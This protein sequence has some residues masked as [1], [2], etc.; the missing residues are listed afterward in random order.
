MVPGLKA[1]TNVVPIPFSS[2]PLMGPCHNRQGKNSGFSAHLSQGNLGALEQFLGSSWHS[3]PEVHSL[4]ISRMKLCPALAAFCSDLHLGAPQLKGVSPAPAATH[5][6]SLA[7]II[8]ERTGREKPLTITHPQMWS[9]GVFEVLFLSGHVHI[10]SREEHYNL[11]CHY[12][13]QVP[14]IGCTCTLSNKTGCECHRRAT[15]VPASFS[16]EIWGP[17][18]VSGQKTST[19]APL[20]QLVQPLL[21]TFASHRTSI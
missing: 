12:T 14:T 8:A 21:E 20:P 9:L 2:A 7:A 16:H 13:M 18:P 3:N 10:S 5:S 15:V 4:I 11:C 1:L 6:W 19:S 17:I